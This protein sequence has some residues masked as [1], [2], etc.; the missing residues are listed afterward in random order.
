MSLRFS[1]DGPA[2][3]E[4][5]VDALLA[6][7]VV[8]LCGAGISTPQLPMFAKLVE[9]C[10][11]RLG[12]EKNSSEIASF[13]KGRYEEVL[14]SL[15]R[16]TVDIGDVSR[17]VVSILQECSEGADLTNHKTILKLSRNLDNRPTVITTNFDTLLE[18]A[19][20]EAEGQG[21]S[22][23]FSFAGQDLPLPGSTEFCG[24]IHL[25]G[26]M[27]DDTI[28]LKQT[29][30]VLTSA[31]YGDAYM[32]SGWASRFLFDLCRCKT[33]VLIGYSAGDAPVRYFLNVLEADRSR[34]PDVHPVY[35]FASVESKN[36]PDTQWS[37]LGVRP[38]AYEFSIDQSGQ[39]CHESL[40]RD[41]DKLAELVE[42]P[43]S[44]RKEWA[45]KIIGKPY[46]S[47]EPDELDCVLWLL[48]GGRNLFSTAI[49]TIEDPEWFDFLHSQEVWDERDASWVTATWVTK[50][51]NSADRFR[52]AIRW[53]GKLG[54]PFA[55]ALGKNYESSKPPSVFWQQAW[56]ILISSQT[57][58]LI[59]PDLKIYAATKT[60]QGSIVLN[61]DLYDAIELISPVFRITPRYDSGKNPP[62]R[63]SDVLGVD[64]T[65]SEQYEVQELIEALLELKAPC[66]ILEIASGK[67]SKFIA[68][69]ADLDEI[70]E[71]YDRNDYAVPSVEPH[72]QNE[73]YDGPIFLVQLIAGLISASSEE[74]SFKTLSIVNAWRS[75]P[76]ILGA[77]LWMHA[78]RDKNLFTDEEAI[79]GVS[80]TSLEIFWSIRRE[81]PLVLRDRAM[82]ATSHTLEKIEHRILTEG[83]AYY[84]RFEIEDSSIDWREHARDLA[85]WLRLNMLN[86]AGVLSANGKYE[87][88]LI[89]SRRE[90]LDRDVEDQ[91]F[92]GSY[93]YGV[94]TLDGD[95][96]PLIEATEEDRLKIAQEVAESPDLR[97][98]L[99]WGVYCRSDAIGAFDTLSKTAPADSNTKLWNTF[100]NSLLLSQED[101]DLSRTKLIARVLDFL[102]SANNSFLS[103]VVGSLSYLYSNISFQMRSEHC[104]WWPRLFLL[105]VK[106]NAGALDST[107]D[108]YHD[109]INSPCGRLTQILLADIDECRKTNN[110]TRSDLMLNLKQAASAKGQEG[111][112]S[113]A[114]LIRNAVFTLSLNN[115]E[116]DEILDSSLTG[117]SEEA[118]ALRSIL[119]NLTEN[120]PNISMRLSK[121]ILTGALEVKGRG[122]VA[123]AA[124]AKII[125]PALLHIS[126]DENADRWGITLEQ[127]ELALKNGPSIL[128]VG[129]SIILKQ[130]MSAPGKDRAKV[131]RSSVGPLLARWSRDR[132]LCEKELTHHF[133][134]IAVAS[135]E[136]FP[137]A[138]QQVFPYLTFQQGY[139][140]LHSLISSD[141]PEKFPRETLVLLWRLFGPGCTAIPYE[142][143]KLLDRLVESEPAIEM[144]RRLQW[145]DQNGIRYE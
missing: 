35:A 122:G 20:E 137:E 82:G 48:K 60:I 32:R 64:W 108:L 36:G 75:M 92:F 74:N 88:D 106:S 44:T 111:A 89:K 25:H 90:Y 109:A 41:L 84:D 110:K 61:T 119:V 33:V 53:M 15:S 118:I 130:W 103:S 67:L 129:A 16:R 87:L 69:S 14:G 142:V 81:L 139:G 13:D 141:I 140:N 40:W 73:H 83:S 12:L 8:F 117:D 59:K 133:A 24:I 46:R 132:D 114:T 96:Q 4:Q 52:Q 79:N 107:R 29:P 27:A 37:T 45:Q 101:T 56:R 49:N 125:V 22:Q 54:T 97:K 121:H 124:A 78:L 17:K 127:T 85:V 134:D 66:K 6:G 143:S 55:D 19:L 68:T 51:L 120:S 39:Q 135:A 126:N 123:R 65:V 138:L 102:S 94:Q 116:V 5:L 57:H 112:F 18:K 131:W 71:S 86:A 11:T 80:E 28:N 10:A 42:R 98:Q 21:F 113:R 72:K 70:D 31:E 34:F 95:A 99:G 2:F 105:A 58:A 136:A 3:P 9:T 30:M 7:E 47:T 43:R 91:D 128:R 76:G 104:E 93:S 115:Q 23:N 50:D 26:R 1:H 63:L 62:E 38:L 144:D 100:I 77:R 145:L